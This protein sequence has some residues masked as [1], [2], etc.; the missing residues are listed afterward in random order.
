MA[1]VA[2]AGARAVLVTPGPWTPLVAVTLVASLALAQVWR[3]PLVVARRMAAAAIPAGVPARTA[4][5][6]ASL[7]L[8]AATAPP[9]IRASAVMSAA[10]L[11]ST[12]LGSV[13]L[14]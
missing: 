6:L 11:A 8:M 7:T 14:G 2:T 12:L 1:V 5:T 4:A 10:V 13:V 9:V 3:V